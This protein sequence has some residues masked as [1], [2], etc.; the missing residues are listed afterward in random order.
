MWRDD[1]LSAGMPWKYL[2]IK[3]NDNIFLTIH[4]YRNRITYNS[5]ISDMN[6]NTYI[7]LFDSSHAR[8]FFTSNGPKVMG[9]S[10]IEVLGLLSLS[11]L[12]MCKY[13]PFFP[14]R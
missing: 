8:M 3:K 6:E 7:V 5:R 4:Q 11:T 9:C 14:S 13:F 1:E 2:K 12:M 10:R